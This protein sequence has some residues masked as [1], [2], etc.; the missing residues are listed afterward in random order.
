MYLMAGTMN[1]PSK[2]YHFEITVPTEELAEMIS[3]Y[4]G[5]FELEAK[6][7]MRK[8]MFVVYLKDGTQI[9]DLLKVMEAY[10]ALLQ[11]ENERAMKEMRGSI[12]RRVNCEVS[13]L[14]KT[15]AAAR[16]QIEDI[17]LI[18]QITGFQSLPPTLFEMAQ[19]RM[20]YPEASLQELG[21]RLH[22]PIG[23]SGV[24]HRLQKL[25]VF[26]AGLRS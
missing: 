23:R 11:Y 18:E 22:P 7:T 20:A 17:Q 5:I 9:A 6:V 3:S 2:S 24:N 19:L 16:K 21:E 15:A 4:I 8:D 26:A 13:N 10:V 25:S 14:N 1:D 12:N